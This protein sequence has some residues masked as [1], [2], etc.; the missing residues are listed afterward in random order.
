MKVWRSY[1]SEHSA[2]LVMVGRFKDAGAAAEAKEIIDLMTKQVREDIDN[3]RLKVGERSEHCTEGILALLRKTNTWSLAAMEFEQFAY[4]VSISVRGNEIE[5]R[6]D[7]SDVSAFFKIMFEK[8]A[9]VEI[10]SA[11]SYKEGADEGKP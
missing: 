4:D 9:R 1:G 2:N 10:Y 8:E 5:L 6:T 11:H 3:D 7:E